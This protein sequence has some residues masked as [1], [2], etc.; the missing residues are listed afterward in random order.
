MTCSKSF[1][2]QNPSSIGAVGT[3]LA[4]SSSISNG[5]FRV[6]TVGGT[7]TFHS[8]EKAVGAHTSK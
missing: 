7:A 1:P 4:G 8:D 6:G 5:V 2:M 3:R